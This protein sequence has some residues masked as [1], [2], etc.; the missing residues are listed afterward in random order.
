MAAGKDTSRSAI[1]DRLAEPVLAYGERLA[2]VQGED[3]NDLLRHAATLLDRFA[4][5]AQRAGA[6]PSTIPPARYALALIL[7][8]KARANPAHELRLWAAG[9]HR[10]L[11]D[12]R[13]ISTGT[14]QDF[15]R[16]AALAGH[17][18]DGVRVFLESCLARIEGQRRRFDTSQGTNWTGIVTV[19]IAAFA[20]AVVGWAGFVE[21]RF[22]RDLTRVFQA[23]ALQIGLDRDGE[24]PDLAPRLGQ[25]ANA[26]ARVRAERDKAPLTLFSGLA[27][28]DA[29]TLAD[30]DYQ[31]AVQRHLPAVS[32]AGGRSDHCVRRGCLCS[33]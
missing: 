10:F 12:G 33:L 19:L 23:E 17:D 20:L 7:D 31:G 29:A 22:H 6:I 4:A 5:D 3:M 18:F 11:F 1:F 14:L 9:A 26:V 25:L 24:I 28:F 16:K 27:G 2:T 21:W 13:D 8:V 32:G 30:A 15:I